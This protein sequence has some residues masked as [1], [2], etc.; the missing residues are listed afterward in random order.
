MKKVIWIVSFLLLFTAATVIRAEIRD[1]T[2]LDARTRDVAKTLRCTVCQN[3]SIWDS[4]AD[5]A[6]QMREVVRERLAQGQSPEEIQAYFQSRYGDYI[7]LEPRKSGLNWLLWAGPFVLLIVGGVILYIVMRRWVSGTKD[8]SV[9][10]M[11]A[12]DEA[13]R[14]RIEEEL[15]SFDK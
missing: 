12:L 9:E 2:D 5:L 8:T 10:E 14:R 6:K 13:H 11:P 4:K 7:L 1:E 3:E 15:K